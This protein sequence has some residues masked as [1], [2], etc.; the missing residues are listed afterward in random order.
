MRVPIVYI[1]RYYVNDIVADSAWF[2]ETA[3]TLSE[4]LYHASKLFKVDVI[5]NRH[6]YFTFVTDVTVF[7]LQPTRKSFPIYWEKHIGTLKVETRA[8]LKDDRLEVV[9]TY[10]IRIDY[11]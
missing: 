6:L 5:R 10:T 4:L 11:I 3:A 9:K 8:S 1:R 2:N 7:N